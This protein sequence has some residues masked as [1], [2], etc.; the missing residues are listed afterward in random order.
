MYYY[1][2]Y[3]RIVEAD[4]LYDA[5]EQN[6]SESLVGIIYLGDELSEEVNLSGS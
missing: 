1:N 4:N 5:I 3:N 2:D 6:W